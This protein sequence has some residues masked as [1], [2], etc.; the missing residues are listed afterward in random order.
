M[1]DERKTKRQLIKELEE[2]RRRISKL[3]KEGGGR[4]RAE[5]ALRQSEE[6]FKTAAK[7]ATDLIYEWDPETAKMNWYGDIDEMLGYAPDEFPRDLERM[8][9]YIHPDDRERVLKSVE[10]HIKT[11]EP[12]VEEYRLRKKNQDYLVISSRGIA[13]EDKDRMLR[14]WI[15]VNTDITE[16]KQTEKKLRES[17]EKYR[18][19]AENVFD[20]I[21]TTDMNWNLTYI[22]PS[23]TKYSGY[24][25]EELMA[26]PTEKRVTPE[27][28]EL[29]TR[30][31]ANSLATVNKDPKR[32]EEFLAL[33]ID[34]YKKDGSTYPVELKASFL[35]DSEGRP[36][37]ILGVNRD[38]TER[39]RAE[40]ALRKSEERYR[41]L[42]EDS[43]DA[44]FINTQDGRLI[45]INQ[46]GLD[47]FGYTR[48]E[49]TRLEIEKLYANP[50]DRKRFQQE[51]EQKGSVR[52]FEIKFRRKD[53]TE[54]DCL[55]T[56]TAVRANDGT[57]LGYK[58]TIRDI[59]DRKHM[60][61]EI[62][63]VAEEWRRTFD[64]IPEMIILIDSRHRIVRVNLEVVRELDLQVPEILGKPYYRLIYGTDSPPESCPYVQTLADG[65]EHSTEMHFDV[66]DRDYV[67]TSSPLLDDEDHLAGSVLVLRDVTERNRLEKELQ[68][69][70]RL[71]SLGIFAGGIAH[72]FNNILS[73]MLLNT[74]Y[75]K[76]LVNPGDKV[77]NLLTE[78]ENTTMRARD[79]TQQL[80]TFSKGGA[81]VK[82]T[83]YVG[84][85]IKDSAVFVLRG[86]NIKCELS[87]PEDLWQVEVDPVQISQ[88]IHN[89]IINAKQAMPK[90]GIIEV[91]A[92]NIVMDNKE[93][94][95]L[96][97]DNFIKI[98]IK[99]EGIGIPEEYLSKIFDP[100]FSTKQEGSGLGLATSYSIIKKHD[101]LITAE[102]KLGVGTTFY[103]YLPRSD[104]EVTEAKIS[105]DV[106]PAVKGK[107]LLMDD[108]KI[109]RDSIG[110]ILEHI[111]FEVESAIDGAEAVE[112]YRKSMEAGEPFDAVILD[113]TIPGGMGGKEAIKKLIQLDPDVKA[114]VSSGYSND[115]V[116]ANFKDHGFQAVIVKPFEYKALR[117]VLYNLIASNE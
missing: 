75:A 17:E 85:I 101:G 89:L 87:I 21:W 74:S 54:I 19:L 16:R 28:F 102:S 20:I 5:E 48:E 106:Y 99:D 57:I 50:S 79:L 88:V 59:T 27:S 55:V 34:Y 49:L 93:F 77:Y 13:I 8:N 29:L 23:V 94:P 2:L 67:I 6:R 112:L 12:F 52:D 37:G 51:I 58:G 44:I 25:V 7:L 104:K 31:L 82:E 95:S 1:R 65:K 105:E 73:G 22:S 4:K 61:D 81:P 92:E 111:G 71:E 110:M 39:K 63:K 86:S 9:E 56:S 35:R 30:A 109:I 116:M 66:F 114:I 45:N 97:K 46:S 108:E 33:E 91:K 62:H 10:N 53:M 68:K 69:A 41:T 42:F 90:G 32:I 84:E 36:I 15:G 78:A 98:Y 70:Q 14:R 96:K 83:T 103:I 76:M 3:E 117:K 26:L 11:G 64:T 72:D 18:L 38:I 113:L 80:L 60:E 115:P 107:I 40:E 43:R 100:F 24:T 47:L